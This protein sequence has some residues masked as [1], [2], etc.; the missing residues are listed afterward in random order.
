MKENYVYHHQQ[1]CRLVVTTLRG[2]IWFVL[3]SPIAYVCVR[4]LATL[5]VIKLMV[6]ARRRRWIMSFPSFSPR[7]AWENACT[8][9]SGVG[10]FQCDRRW[11]SNV[12]ILLTDCYCRCASSC[13][14]VCLTRGYYWLKVPALLRLSYPNSQNGNTSTNTFCIS[15]ASNVYLSFRV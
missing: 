6:L 1:Q 5:S 10:N 4:L 2:H 8:L 15:L 12:V 11:P 14:L 3:V 13:I 7:A 9:F